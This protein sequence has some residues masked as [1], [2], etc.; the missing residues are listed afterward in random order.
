MI[1]LNNDSL[2]PCS[3]LKY[4]SG[5]FLSICHDY[6]NHIY[7]SNKSNVIH[8]MRSIKYFIFFSKK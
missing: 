7:I 1:T 4:S 3:V 2:V 8:N 5:F 6:M